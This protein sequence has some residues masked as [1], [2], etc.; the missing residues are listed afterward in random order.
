MPRTTRAC[1]SG[2][3]PYPHLPC[4]STRCFPRDNSLSHPC[5]YPADEMR[6]AQLLLHRRSF[7]SGLEGRCCVFVLHIISRACPFVS[8]CS[9]SRRRSAAVIVW[10][11]FVFCPAP[12]GRRHA[13]GLSELICCT[14]WP[15][16]LIRSMKGWPIG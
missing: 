13:I 4:A 2:Q 1:L 8:T 3:A 15:F 6:L 16:S 5:L 10:M 12:V 11:R 7:A 14:A 9:L